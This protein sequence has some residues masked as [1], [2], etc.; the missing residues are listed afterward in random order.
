M[1]RKLFILLFGL[2]LSGKSISDSKLR[3]PELAN[4][5]PWIYGPQD[6]EPLFSQRAVQ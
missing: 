4:I 1:G 5:W 6:L 2:T 3:K